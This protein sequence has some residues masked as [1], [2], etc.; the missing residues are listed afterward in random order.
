MS[1]QIP[2]IVIAIIGAYLIGSPPTAYI[3]GRLRKGIDIR[4]VGTRNMGAMNVFYTVGFAE[5][6][7]VLAVDIGKGV[8][9][10]ALA[11]WLGVPL[12]A[13][14]FAGAAVVI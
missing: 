8:A 6:I 12:V 14:L 7:T 1:S 3:M 11:R 2:Y 5:G 13:Q 4:K 10:V 9:A